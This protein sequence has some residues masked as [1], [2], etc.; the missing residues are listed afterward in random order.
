MTKPHHCLQSTEV[1]IRLYYDSQTMEPVR[2]RITNTDLKGPMI[3]LIQK[4]A[5]EMYEAEDA[6]T[7]D[8]VEAYIEKITQE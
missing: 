7:R 1:Y 3:H 2:R 8:T 6:E 4:V 5:K